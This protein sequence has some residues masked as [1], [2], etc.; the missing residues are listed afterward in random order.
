MEIDI[1]FYNKNLWNI[2][3]PKNKTRENSNFKFTLRINTSST[4]DSQNK[5]TPHQNT[6]MLSRKLE[7]V[8]DFTRNYYKASLSL[9]KHN[10]SI[11]IT[12]RKQQQQN[13]KSL[14]LKGKIHGTKICFTFF[15]LLPSL[16]S[17][18]TC[19]RQ[20]IIP[21]TRHK[22]ESNIFF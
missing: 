12:L 13:K 14:F 1:I 5:F 11:N 6:E 2:L 7:N 9:R 22:I 15:R 21:P 8:C 20:E 19:E 16:T 4:F 17:T 10:H 18:R 3:L